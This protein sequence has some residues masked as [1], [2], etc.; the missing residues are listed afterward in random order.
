ML[1]FDSDTKGKENVDVKYIVFI[2]GID[3]GDLTSGCLSEV[4]AVI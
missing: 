1:N 3:R 2:V 4:V